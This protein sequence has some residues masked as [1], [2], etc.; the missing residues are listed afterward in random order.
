[1]A[2]LKDSKNAKDQSKARVYNAQ[3]TSTGGFISGEVK[4]AITLRILAVGSYLDMA[5]LYETGESYSHLIFFMMLL[6]IGF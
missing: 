1:L 4:L 3:E 5:L 6:R 2:N